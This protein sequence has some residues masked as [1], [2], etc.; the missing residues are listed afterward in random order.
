MKNI[1]IVL[2]AFGLFSCEDVIDIDVKNGGKQ[3]V[4]DAWLVQNGETQTIKLSYSQDYFNQNSPEPVLG[5]EVK[6]ILHDSSQIVFL[7]KNQNGNYTYPSGFFLEE[8]QPVG[9]YIKHNGE[10]YYSIS[11]LNRVPSIENVIYEEFTLPVKPSTGPQTGYL[12]QFEAH[13]YVGEGDTY[14]IRWQKDNERVME[15]NSFNLAYDA[16]GSPTSKLD[17]MAF[18]QP[19][20]SSSALGLLEHG[21]AV[22]VELF[23]IPLDAYYYLT[24]LKNETNNGGIFGTP[25]ANVKG[26]IL[27]RNSDSKNKALGVF[28]VSKVSRFSLIIDKAQALPK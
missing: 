19:L 21:E 12:A 9:L 15:P 26:N 14:L 8:N 20:R 17:G 6:V 2:L 27:N 24:M 10:E 23:S 16:G 11:K 3:L 1:W 22:S 25:P 7:D 18:I 5:A 4:V 13:D 28:F